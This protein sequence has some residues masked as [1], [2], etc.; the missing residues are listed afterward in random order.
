MLKI[1]TKCWT[2]GVC[3]PQIVTII[4]LLKL[5]TLVKSSLIKQKLK[6]NV[7]IKCILLQNFIVKQYYKIYIIQII[8]TAFNLY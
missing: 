1:A 2:Q 3:R 8:P 7:D 4:Y 6:K 5:V